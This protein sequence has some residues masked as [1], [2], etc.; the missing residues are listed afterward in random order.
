M[1]KN[2]FNQYVRVFV[3]V[4]LA[5]AGRGLPADELVMQDGSR[6][7]GKV[8]GGT[9]G[10]LDFETG[11]AGVLKVQWDQIS[12]MRTDT[13][14]RLLLG[15]D[16]VLEI[17]TARESGE[18]LLVGDGAEVLRSLD[19][20]DVVVV[21][22]EPWRLGDGIRWTGRVNLELKTERGNTDTDEFEA[23]G[24]MRFRRVRDRMTF[25][26]QYE[27]DKSSGELTTNNW[28]ASGKYD[29]FFGEKFYAGAQ[30]RLEH[31]EFA[32]LDLRTSIGPHVGYQFYE[33]VAMNFNMDAGLLYVDEDYIESP[34][35]DYIALG[36][37]VNFDRF[38][39]PE[40]VQFYHR[41]TGTMDTGDT[42]NTAIDSWTGFR[43]PLYAGIVAS[44]EAEVNYDGGAPDDVDNTD[45]TYRLKL[46]YQ[47]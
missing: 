44:A 29:Y 15:D 35:D 41:H 46:G 39:I 20:S 6:L 7:V 40:R 10:V 37:N 1:K 2:R 3:C 33:S 4:F 27:K 9:D 19:R 5:L 24:E 16:E 36:W 34:D 13:P 31:D 28:E 23:D 21:N 43:F 14:V 45:T 47:W 30:L 32:D 38:L 25:L 11:F 17:T 22:P 18:E 12:E 26:G 8:L 42:G